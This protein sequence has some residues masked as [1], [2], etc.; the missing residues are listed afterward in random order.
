[1]KI[2]GV[3]QKSDLNYIISTIGTIT[4]NSFNEDFDIEFDMENVIQESSKLKE[5][6]YKI[7]IEAYTQDGTMLQKNMMKNVYEFEIIK[8]DNYGLDAKITNN[9]ESSDKLQIFNKEN[10][11]KS[12]EIKIQKGD[13]DNPYIKIKLQKR[14]SVFTYTDI[15]NTIVPNTIESINLKE[16]NV[17]KI[18]S[19][20]ESGMYRIVITLYD[21]SNNE[22]TEKT[23]NFIVE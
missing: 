10:K 3:Q 8:K 21:E 22:Y 1:M 18:N 11:N 9:G 2:N 14:T 15:E 19:D 7:I 13:L 20:L 16:N 12:L 23:I 5:G 6:N 4:K 17:L